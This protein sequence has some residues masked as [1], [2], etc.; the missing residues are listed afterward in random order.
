MSY[1]RGSMV[2]VR[3]VEKRWRALY[4]LIRKLGALSLVVILLFPVC[5]TADDFHTCTLHRFPFSSHPF[6]FSPT[7][8]NEQVDH[9]E[10]LACQWQV[11]A[12]APLLAILL[13]TVFPTYR[14]GRSEQTDPLPLRIHT[15]RQ[16][17]RPAFTSFFFLIAPPSSSSLSMQRTLRSSFPC[18]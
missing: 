16:E 10:C 9:P 1:P 13:H 11:I 2:T 5:S 18:L 14:P 8:D 12:D 17:T 3:W 15:V 4:R 6:Q 7:A